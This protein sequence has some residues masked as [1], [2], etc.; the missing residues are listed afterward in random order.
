MRRAALPEATYAGFRHTVSEAF[1]FYGRIVLAPHRDSD[2]AA[3]SRPSCRIRYPNASRRVSE[4]GARTI[5]PRNSGRTA[6]PQSPVCQKS[7]GNGVP[8]NRFLHKH[9]RTDKRSVFGIY[10]TTA[11]LSSVGK[12]MIAPC[13]P[14]RGRRQATISHEHPDSFD[15]CRQ[16]SGIF[17]IIRLFYIEQ[18]KKNIEK[19][20]SF[21]DLFCQ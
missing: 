2:C 6:S 19:R 16:A 13:R 5:R 3:F 21:T 18:K 4:C 20:Y 11:A 9:A 8:E 17:I 7:M 15:T 1:S 14:T 10:F 12:S